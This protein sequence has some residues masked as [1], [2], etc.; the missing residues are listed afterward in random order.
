[1]DDEQVDPDYKKGF[2][3]AY[4]LQKEGGKNHYDDL[5]SLHESIPE[6]KEGNLY[7]GMEAGSKQAEADMERDMGN[8]YRDSLVT[9]YG[10][11]RDG[12]LS[13]P[14]YDGHDE[15]V[16]A[17]EQRQQDE[18]ISTR[19]LTHE[20]QKAHYDARDDFE[21]R[22]KNGLTPQQKKEAQEFLDTYDEREKRVQDKI[23]HDKKHNT[24]ME[25]GRANSNF[26]EQGQT[27]E[28]IREE[29]LKK[30]REELSKN[31]NNSKGQGRKGL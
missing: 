31:K 27:P 2:N 25:V 29:E 5:I 19:P 24:K 21:K 18:Y 23:A 7:R 6:L 12:I 8:M 15:K 9:D 26:V 30:F 1:M 3:L 11:N 22:E 16:A 13:Q 10:N 28:Q 4:T 17:V 14:N 20:E